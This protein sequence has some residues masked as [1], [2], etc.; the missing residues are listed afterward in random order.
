MTYNE[1]D[2]AFLQAID[3]EISCPPPNIYPTVIR[4][5]GRTFMQDIE[6]N[7]IDVDNTVLGGGDISGEMNLM[8]ENEVI[9][10]NCWDGSVIRQDNYFYMQHCILEDEGLNVIKVMEYNKITKTHIEATVCPF[11]VGFYGGGGGHI[12]LSLV[13][14]RKILVLSDHFTEYLGVA[15]NR[16]YTS[17]IYS[18]DFSSG[19]GIVD[20]E[21]T[22][23]N[24][25]ETAYNSDPP[26]EHY[27]QETESVIGIEIAG[28]IWGF[29]IGNEWFTWD[30][31][32]GDYTY[33][34]GVCVY[35]K[36]FSTGSEWEL[37]VLSTEVEPIRDVG[38]EAWLTCNPVIVGKEKIIISAYVYPWGSGVPYSGLELWMFDLNTHE[39][40]R[41]GIS[42][43]FGGEETIIAYD[44]SSG[45]VHFLD[46]GPDYEDFLCLNAYN[47]DTDVWTENIW[48]DADDTWELYSYLLA[49]KDHI[50][51]YTDNGKRMLRANGLDEPNLLGIIPTEGEYGW[52]SCY[53]CFAVDSY[54]PSVILYDCNLDNPSQWYLRHIGMDGTIH[55][56]YT[57]E[58]LGL[59]QWRAYI[60][61]M[62]D[63][64]AILESPF[65][66]GHW[67]YYLL[68]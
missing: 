64:Y 67:L 48:G 8:I 56:E 3:V 68:T 53:F 19:T 25:F 51:I 43:H 52:D 34:Y 7:I 62:V 44:A 66:N 32:D 31:G 39:L 24:S 35:Y 30:W 50:Y 29:V 12:R 15:P 33:R 65:S 58:E 9:D 60:V 13:G 63:S 38:I 59:T 61:H 5:T 57:A 42:N 37:K 18:V 2:N 4:N 21:F 6:N 41:S 40:T 45:L 28:N 36:N 54:E 1:Y 46:Y 47:P 55:W 26:P 16:Y 17:T 23:N 11:R 22:Y 49:S 14:N 27:T 20:V 10:D